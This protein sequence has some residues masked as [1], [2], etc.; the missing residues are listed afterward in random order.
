MIRRFH[1]LNT[2]DFLEEHQEDFGA[3]M[4][5]LNLVGKPAKASRE[6]VMNLIRERNLYNML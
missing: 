4:K 2:K 6:N 5:T 1:W 3:K